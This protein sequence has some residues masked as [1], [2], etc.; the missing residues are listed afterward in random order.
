MNIGKITQHCSIFS[1]LQKQSKETENRDTV[2]YRCWQDSYV[3]IRKIMVQFFFGIL[4]TKTEPM[5][6]EKSK[7][8][9][10]EWFPTRTEQSFY[11]YNNFT[12]FWTV[13]WQM[14]A[15]KTELK[16]SKFLLAFQSSILLKN[17]GPNSREAFIQVK[18]VWKFFCV[19]RGNLRA[20][21]FCP[22]PLRI[23]GYWPEWRPSTDV[24]F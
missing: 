23:Q 21:L 7:Q 10:D 13:H 2:F 8:E 16:W 22:G 15:F 4:R 14:W 20:T 6:E 24:K 17:M 19:S 18:M 11:D 3:H 5:G 9:R 12:N 1:W